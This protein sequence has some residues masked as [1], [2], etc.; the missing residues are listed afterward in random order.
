MSLVFSFTNYIPLS[1]S[2][3]TAVVLFPL[4]ALHYR[5][6]HKIFLYTLLLTAYFFINTCLYYPQSFLDYDFYRRDGNFFITFAP[7]LTLP[8]FKINFDLKSAVK[9]FIIWISGV[10]LLFTLKFLALRHSEDYHFLFY[11][12]NAA[13]GYLGLLSSLSIGYYLATKKRFYLLLSLLN[14]LSLWLTGSRGSVVGFAC[15]LLVFWCFRRKIIPR[16]VVTS[17]VLAKVLMMV[18]VFYMATSF[19]AVGHEFYEPDPNA[20]THSGEGLNYL[21]DVVP[22]GGNII[23]RFFFLWPRALFLFIKS[24]IFGT[25]FGSYNDYPYI[26]HG[27][28]YLAYFNTPMHPGMYND[29]HAHESFLHILAETGLVGFFLFILVLKAMWSFIKKIPDPEVS[30]GLQ[31]AFWFNVFSSM[32]EHRFFTPSQ[33]IAFTIILGLAI[34]VYRKKQGQTLPAQENNR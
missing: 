8:L 23:S 17:I 4:F 26:F 5:T 31:I 11:A 2:I 25:G 21:Q 33:M 34:A 28:K 32:T 7:L 27:T 6:H 20:L 15:G 1:V 12:H 22:R 14:L 29:G 13:G 10:N 30:F 9:T 16:F 24:P 3:C 18:M 19:F